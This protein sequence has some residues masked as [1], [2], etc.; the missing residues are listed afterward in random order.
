[1]KTGSAPAWKRPTY[2]D[3]ERLPPHVVGE[4]IAG[5]LVV[6][7]RPSPRHALAGSGLGGILV[8]PFGHGS[9]G[10]GGWWIL[11]EPE[12]HL[13][14]DPDYEV[15]VPDFGGWRV[16]RM[17]QVPETAWFSVVPDWVCEVLSPSTAAID[18]AEK[19]PF[20][21]RAGVGHAWMLDPAART[22]E[23]Y[24][25]SGDNWVLV[26]A[27]RGAATVRA[28]PFDAIEF[29]LGLLWDRPG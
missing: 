4:I 17:P 14:I 10:P 25:R 20:Y 12:L 13:G 16:E 24:R 5:E 7:P 28:E 2:E 1:M 15:V 27:W 6:S 19:L 18:R 22:L 21:A 3:I 11:Y 8:P 23:S 9:G 29:R 26:G